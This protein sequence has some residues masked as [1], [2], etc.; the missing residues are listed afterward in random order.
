MLNGGDSV[1]FS[2]SLWK[3]RGDFTAEGLGDCSDYFIIK[4]LLIQLLVMS[5]WFCLFQKPMTEPLLGHDFFNSPMNP[6]KQK[7]SF[8]RMLPAG[9]EMKL[10]I[11]LFKQNW[12]VRCFLPSVLPSPKIFSWKYETLLLFH[13]HK[14]PTLNKKVDSGQWFS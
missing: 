11:K 13:L 2:V 1:S 3:Y 9:T 10:L 6:K 8:F 5:Q 14:A 12:E 4:I 7:L